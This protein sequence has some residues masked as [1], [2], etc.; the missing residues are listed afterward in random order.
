MTRTVTRHAEGITIA[1]TYSDG[2]GCTWTFRNHELAAKREE[3]RAFGVSVD[4][5]AL[6]VVSVPARVKS[7]VKPAAKPKAKGRRK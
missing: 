2:T 4:A 3:L 6:E 7:A 5:D 1:D